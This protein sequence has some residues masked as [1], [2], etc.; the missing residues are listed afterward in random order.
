MTGFGVSAIDGAVRLM[1][2][3]GSPFSDKLETPLNPRDAKDLYLMAGKNKI[4]VAFLQ[5]LMRQNALVEFALEEEY[6]EEMKR[7]SLQISTLT[8]LCGILERERASYATFKTV[9]P[10]PATTNDVD[11]VHFGAADEL[12]RLTA[13]LISS[14]YAQVFGEVDADQSMFHDTLLGGF[15]ADHPKQKDVFDVDIYQNISAS[16]LSYFDKRRLVGEII[17]QEIDGTDVNILTPHSELALEIVHSIV[18]EMMYT[19][20]V[21]YSSLH[22]LSRMDEE[23]LMRF[24]EMSRSNRITSAVRAHFTVTAVLHES[25][26]GFI[27]DE[28]DYIL[29]EIDEDKRIRKSLL[30]KE[31]SLPL[32]YDY[33]TLISVL[34]EKMGEGVFRRSA[35]D[36]LIYTTANTTRIK[37]VLGNIMW[38]KKRETY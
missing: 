30:R 17:K 29:K 34:F 6:S 8:R 20:L 26:F 18:P 31:V 2:V 23:S 37:W 36:Q 25:A 14:G 28:I 22:H 15:V 16:R 24:L 27:P 35:L 9:M 38:R 12:S 11:I 10:F 21:S 4:G 3:I 5:S 33:G 7:H 32:K 13:R 19:L 1:R